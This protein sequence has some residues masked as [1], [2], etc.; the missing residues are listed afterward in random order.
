MEIV[1]Q[2]KQGIQNIIIGIERIYK[3]QNNL[4]LVPKDETAERTYLDVNMYE[5]LRIIEEE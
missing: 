3:F 2:N 5:L 4:V 1:Y